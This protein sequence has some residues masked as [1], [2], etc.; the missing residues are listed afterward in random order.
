M[1]NLDDFITNIVKKEINE[2]E[3]YETSIRNAFNAKSYKKLKLKRM[4]SAVCS[5]LVITTGIVYASD[6][7]ELVS[8]Y[9]YNFNEGVD[10]AIEN[11]YFD[12]PENEYANS[13][14]VNGFENGDLVDASNT[15][16]KVKDM[17]MDDYNL[18]FTFSIK[19]DK[20][21]NIDKIKNVRLNKVLITDENNSI[22]FCDLNKEIFDKYCEKNNL[23]YKYLEF[24]E[25]YIDSGFNY[26]ISSKK[27]ENGIIELT[28]NLYNNQNYPYPK[29][30]K[31]N[32]QINEIY[33]TEKDTSFDEEIVLKGNWNI[34][35][36]I[37]EKFS[38]RDDI[39]YV[40]KK[41]NYDDINVTEAILHDTGFSYKFN[42]P[43]VPYYNEKD[44]EEVKKQKVDKYNAYYTND[45]KKI[46][47]K[48]ITDCYIENEL[49]KKFYQPSSGVPNQ[50]NTDILTSDYLYYTDTFS[51][52]KADQTDTLKIY[53][54][55][56]LPD[57]QR[58]VC[59]ELEKEK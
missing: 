31:L 32:I 49:G 8:K 26:L 4:I 27:S 24:N 13:N 2:P 12:E 17:I 54:K 39:N 33:M 5:L 34:L 38:N 29:S 20:N 43:K 10:I 30:K 44:S 22:V 16:I 14:D 59:I 28:Y 46:I 50:Y 51:L 36:D 42:L 25:N 53:F 19:V 41:C 7:K 15:E 21:V 57:D 6:I 23:D 37:S 35:F 45:E 47:P 18:S 55:I 52:T 58:D 9:F 1:K 48:P 11:G 3:K 56:N 40:V